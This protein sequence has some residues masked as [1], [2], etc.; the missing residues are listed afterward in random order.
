MS[1]ETRLTPSQKRVLNVLPAVIA[2]IATASVLVAGYMYVN[3]RRQA[4]TIRQ[5]EMKSEQANAAADQFERGSDTLTYEAKMFCETGDMSHFRAYARELT[6]TRDR[7][8]ALQSL[9]RMGLTPREISRIQD[10]KI[11]SDDLSDRELWAM[12]LVA[13]SGGAAESD[14][15]ERIPQ[16][17]LTEEEKN[18]PSE[19]QYSR[20]YKYVMSAAYFTLKNNVDTGVQD[21]SNDLMK[22]Y[23][24]STIEMAELGRSTALVSLGI[25]AVLVLFTV[26][27]S[28]L[29]SRYEK[30]NARELSEA[31]QSARAASRAKSD[32]LSS[33][34]H[35]I[36]T[37]MNAVVGMTSMAQLSLEERDYGRASADLKI[38][39]SSSR[40]LLSLIND[41]LDLS[42]IESGKMV[43]AKEPYALPEALEETGEVVLPLFIAKSQDYR[44]H[45]AGLRHEFV[46]G[47]AV[48]LKQVL[49]NILNN[50][51]KYTPTGGR[52]DF[53][54]EELES[55]APGTAAV[56]F[57]VADNGIGIAPEKLNAIFDPFSREVNT[58]INQV[59]GTG[60]G[61]TIVKSIVDAAG[62]TVGVTSEK[63]KGSAFTVT[64]PLQIQDESQALGR[65]SY[66]RGKKM[67]V[68]EE[69]AGYGADVCAM[70]RQVGALSTCTSSLAAAAKAAAGDGEAPLAA[71]ID[72]ESGA[73]EAVRAIREAAPEQ[74]IILLTG[75][76]KRKELEEC[77]L[78][79]GADGL[80][81]K[82]LFRSTLYERIISVCRRERNSADSQKYLRG[83][84]ILIVDDVE[85]NRM[86]AQMMLENA[87]ALTERAE[88]GREAV[89]KFRESDIGYYDAVLMDVMMPVMGGYEATAEIRALPRP[90]AG[91]V[92]IV[93][94]TANA[95]A[96]DVEKSWA[97]GMSAHISKPVEPA[98][99]QSVLQRVL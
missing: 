24:D 39:Q 15:P 98:D 61:L 5:F 16:G 81:E 23:G 4:D 10:A 25:I 97:A 35:D 94:M 48:R 88:N 20:G 93:A 99:M 66:L 90:D 64:L 56:R 92:P 32:F 13:L 1:G 18:L 30:E 89:E 43:L 3:I 42:K 38:V 7:D 34:S 12:E 8:T 63:G 11:S 41:V 31:M 82:P 46:I 21:F 40:Q 60:L 65:Y 33:M 22:R 53:T 68:V 17:I 85:I 76:E 71:L 95:F 80:L 26:A 86:V 52:I 54:V 19:E 62:G 87:G 72:R 69:S 44:V 73:V 28:V 45:I 96:E 50:A 51:N 58:S 55:A 74:A 2:V 14:F 79:A 36:R 70:L 27:L 29:Y 83:R 47:D 57:A 77:A 6:E 59:E 84:R 67:L 9:F 37:P 78:A 49:I 91:T 75:E